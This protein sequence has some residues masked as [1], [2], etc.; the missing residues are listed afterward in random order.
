MRTS[1]VVVALGCVAASGN[2]AV[3]QTLRTVQLSS[4]Q[5][6]AERLRSCTVGYRTFGR[7][8][9]QRSNAVLV[10]TWLGGTSADWPPL[11]GP[12]KIIDTTEYFVIVV[13]ALANGVSSSPST[14]SAPFP[15]VR[16][17][18]MVASQVR[19][20]REVLGL[21]HLR[22]VVGVSMGG[23]QVFEWA[24]A[25]PTFVDRFVSI[26]GAPQVAR[27]DRTWLRTL[28]RLVEV[29]EAYRVPA[30]TIWRLIAGLGITLGGTPEQTNRRPPEEADAL[31]AA[32]AASL[33][34]SVILT[35]LAAQSRAILGY[36]F[37]DRP[38]S[39]S[40]SASNRLRG[41][42]LVINSSDDHLV[43][44]GPARQFA[45]QVG[46]DTLMLSSECGH[47]LF[48]CEV[49]TI[50]AAIAAFLRR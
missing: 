32:Y 27:H 30:D 15:A 21:E 48:A 44:A 33:S 24:A 13:D 29:G 22:A 10:P 41:R 50:G 23:I 14:A 5:V 3:A 6:G 45:R 25:Y 18:D 2:S 38:G 8:D 19:L 49:R 11:L 28:V 37:F 20:A 7:L 26:V 47:G 40:A 1:A 16:I 4:C 43:S 17:E 35:N 34:T 31:L 39:D 9:D 12:G 46:A 36:N 42:L